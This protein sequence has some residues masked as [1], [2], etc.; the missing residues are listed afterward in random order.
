[1]TRVNFNLAGT[2]PVTIQLGASSLPT[3]GTASSSVY[4]DG[5]SQPGS[6]P[7][8]AAYGTNAIP[9]VE[10]RGQSATNTQW[11]FYVPRVGNTFR[12][13]LLNNTQ[14]GVFFDGPAAAGNVVIGNWMG[15]NRDN[16]L[17]AR[18]IEGVF[19]NNGAHDN[20]VGSPDLADRNVIGNF[21]KAVYS[22]GPGTNNN[23]IQ[24]N[25]LCIKPD[26]STAICQ[27]AIDFDFGPK[28]NLVGGSNPGEG[29]VVGPDCC[30]AVEMSHGWDPAGIDTS[31]K[32]LISGNRII[33]NWLG[34]RADG[35][36]DPSYRSAQSVPTYDN[37]QGVNV[38]D[39]SPNNL[40]QGNYIA[41]VYDGITVASLNTTGNVVQGNI[42]GQSP[43]GQAAPH[44]RLGRL[45][46]LGHG[47]SY[48][49]GQPHQQRGDGRHRADRVQRHAHHPEPEHH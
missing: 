18:G 21:D 47:R 24:N 25:V 37:G 48:A 15:F 12:G 32:W 28:N 46:A 33:G 34:F 14:R 20:I 10:I 42:I 11:I 41:S 5:Y 16:S 2:A 44:V 29:N 26:G 6:R 13:L 19:L 3:V 23:T 22:N 40:V 4:I 43:L 38:Y 27:T 8:D 31:S 30:N 1:M 45:P 17:P 35:S 9:G 49:V 39:G 7:N 36:Y